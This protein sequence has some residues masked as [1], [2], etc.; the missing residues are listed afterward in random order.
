GV[1][2]EN[3]ESL[4][5][6][7]LRWVAQV[8]DRLGARVKAQTDEPLGGVPCADLFQQR[9]RFFDQLVGGLMKSCRKQPE[10]WVFDS[11]SA[12]TFGDAAGAQQDRLPSRLH[13]GAD[14]G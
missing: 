14:D 11:E 1:S 6:V 7:Q 8:V 3:V 10:L 12:G 4:Q 13:R 2:S 5:A 9:R